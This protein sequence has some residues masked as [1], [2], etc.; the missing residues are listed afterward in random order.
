MYSFKYFR[1]FFI[2]AI[3]ALSCGCASVKVDRISPSKTTDIG[4][5]WNDSD[6]RLTAEEM[7]RDCLERPWLHTFVTQ[8]GHNPV[9][10]VGNISNRTHEHINSQVV[11]KA[12]E[13]EL[14]NSGKV[15]FVATS[16]ER[17]GLRA[18]RE[19]QQT[20]SSAETRKAFGREVGA[21]F[22]MIGSLNSVKDVFKTKGTMYYQINLELIDLETNQKVW[23]GQKEIKKMIKKRG[24]K[25]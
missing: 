5:G 15:S 17:Q 7:I 20:F 2:I 14:L 21:D 24:V 10:I 19:D 12:V 16:E 11:I 18:E 1:W 4:G 23:M 25:W 6:A 9:V 13:R 8:Y 3:T 22:M